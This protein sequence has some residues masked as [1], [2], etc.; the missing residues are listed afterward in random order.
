[1]KSRCVETQ[2]YPWLGIY[3]KYKWLQPFNEVECQGDNE[4]WDKLCQRWDKVIKLR[5]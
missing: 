3:V 2:D 4:M 1:M 5:E